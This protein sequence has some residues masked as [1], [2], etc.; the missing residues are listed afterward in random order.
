MKEENNIETKLFHVEEV[1]VPLVKVDYLDYNAMEHSGLLLI[2][3]SNQLNGISNDYVRH[4]SV[5]QSEAVAKKKHLSFIMSGMQ[6]CEPFV[7]V[8]SSLGSYGELPV[9]GS[10]G[11][12]FLSRHRLALD[13]LRMSLHTSMANPNNLSTA[14][15][16]F[17]FPMEIGMNNYG[18]PILSMQQDGKEIIAK[19]NTTY[20]Y[21]IFAKQ[22]LEEDGFHCKF[23][24]GAS[25]TARKAILDFDL[26]TVRED[27]NKLVNYNN[28]FIVVNDYLYQPKEG[29]LD[30]N[31]NKLEPIKAAIGTQFMINE[32]W[33]LDFDQNIIYLK[34]NARP[35]MG[36]LRVKSNGKGEKDM[37][38]IKFY[39]STE[40]K[41]LPF[42]RIDEGAFE[43]LVFLIDTGSNNNVM[44]GYAY[45]QLK[46]LMT[47]EDKKTILYGM[48]G[49]GSEVNSSSCEVRFCGQDYHMSFLIK[50]E[51]G[52][53]KS[54]SQDMGFPIAGIIGTIFMSNHDWLIDFGKQEIVIPSGDVSANALESLHD[55]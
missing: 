28:S 13:F 4:L 22:A 40:E 37:R 42:I 36:D 10:L 33:T 3:V 26:L 15:C 35:W 8:D 38:S 24:E 39:S 14:D 32:G 46:K 50:E 49:K 52:A 19:L 25:G 47:Q 55:K 54:L 9:I 44:W 5:E 23:V 30:E 18:F 17:F 12:D 21:N 43:G 29:A 1:L 11:L 53:G 6:F 7:V 27:E 41:G 45:K 20:M 2:D 31:G 48:E 34:K 51:D 16:D